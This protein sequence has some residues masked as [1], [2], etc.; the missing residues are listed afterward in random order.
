MVLQ[1][2]GLTLIIAVRLMGLGGELILDFVIVK[3][4]G[5]ILECSKM[6]KFIE[7]KNCGKECLDLMFNHTKM[8]VSNDLSEL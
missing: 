2:N 5:V 1:Q 8:E 3:C 6:V 7:L 4:D